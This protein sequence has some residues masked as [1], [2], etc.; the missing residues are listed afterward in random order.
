VITRYLDSGI[1]VLLGFAPGRMPLGH[2]VLAVGAE[3]AANPSVPNASCT[4]AQF[5]SHF[6]VNDD[7]RGAYRR[8]AMKSVDSG[9]YPYCIEQDLTVIVV[10][11]PDK[12]F[13]KAETAEL[14]AT[15]ALTHLASTRHSLAQR[16]LSGKQWD[17]EPG[18]YDAVE[19][20]RVVRRTYLTFGWRYKARAVRNA[21]ASALKEELLAT[22]FPRFVW[23]TEFYSLTGAL[24]PDPDNR[25]VMAHA[26]VDATGS[27]F[28]DSPLVLDAP[29]ISLIWRYDPAGREPSSKRTVLAN[30]V[31]SPSRPKARGVT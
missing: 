12:V 13:M 1:P 10:P 21:F 31:W 8:L 17:V 29:G 11:L 6:L 16:V 22:Q 25:E 3:R 14:A 2:A 20:D 9:A 5:V 4:T 28:T 7:Q 27:R 24:A 26:V 18:F 30:T 15:K 19:A 23:V